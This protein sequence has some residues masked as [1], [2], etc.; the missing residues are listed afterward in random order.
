MHGSNSASHPCVAQKYLAIAG[1]FSEMADPLYP[2]RFLKND[3]FKRLHKI[4]N[5]Y[6]YIFTDSALWAVSV[7]E[8]PCPYVCVSVIKG[9]IVDNGQSIRFFGLSL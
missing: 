7:I 8:P 4:G 2:I 9:V 6:I 1:K 3:Y 5:I